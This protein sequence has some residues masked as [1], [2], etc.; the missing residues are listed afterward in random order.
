MVAMQ[1]QDYPM[2]K[3]AVGV[4][5]PGCTEGSVQEAVSAGEILRTHLLRPTW[6]LVSAADLRWLLDLTG[7]RIRASLRSRLRDLELTPQ[8]LRKS[9]RLIEKLLSGGPRGRDAIVAALNAAGIRTD[10][11]RTSHV[12]LAAELDGIVTS[13]PEERGK[14]TYALLAGRAAAG[15]R[16]PRE[17]AL[18]LLARRYF[19]SRHPATV[20]DFAW[21]SGL[22]LTDASRAVEALGNELRSERVGPATCWMPEDAPAPRRAREQVHL[23]PAFDEYAIS[24]EDREAVLPGTG[25]AGAISSNGIFYPLVVRDG[26]AIGTWKRTRHKDHVSVAVKLFKPL[27]RSGRASL[28]P[29]LDKACQ[30]Y[31][32]FLG[33]DVSA[34]L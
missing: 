14:P 29:L 18:G 20:A 26:R 21:W 15:P 10:E 12:M 2:S 33:A 30:R 31:G 34:Q 23:L 7:P 9:H 1:A 11:N 22:T 17:E 25:S 5:C 3:W 32:I 6:H 13:G 28:E 24:Y 8:V 27:P 16:L 4:R 19:A